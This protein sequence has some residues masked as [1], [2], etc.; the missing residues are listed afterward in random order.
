MNCKVQNL[1]IL[2]AFLL[3]LP[4]KIGAQPHFPDQPVPLPAGVLLVLGSLVGWWRLY[5]LQKNKK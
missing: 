1:L 5:T 2:L 3:S 4:L